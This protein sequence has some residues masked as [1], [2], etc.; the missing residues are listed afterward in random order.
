MPTTYYQNQN[1]SMTLH[2]NFENERLEPETH[3]L[4][5]ELIFQT[6]LDGALGVY[7]IWAMYVF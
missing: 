6:S 3:P 5:R 1:N 2:W 7:D 4:K